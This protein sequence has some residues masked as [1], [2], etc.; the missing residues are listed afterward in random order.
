ML[1]LKDSG[2]TLGEGNE[3]KGVRGG[4]DAERAK[5]RIRHPDI[6]GVINRAVTVK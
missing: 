2:D 6:P 5:N 1:K 3:E 4:T